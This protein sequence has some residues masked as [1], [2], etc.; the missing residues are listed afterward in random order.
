MPVFVLD[1]LAIL[2]VNEN[3]DTERQAFQLADFGDYAPLVPTMRLVDEEE[4]DKEANCRLNNP[5]K[6]I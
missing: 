4:K 3:K 5:P 2:V 1:E 6:E